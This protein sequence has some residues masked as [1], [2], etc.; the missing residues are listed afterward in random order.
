M[1]ERT[2][3]ITA[4]L[5]EC[6]AAGKVPGVAVAAVLPDG[7]VVSAASGVRDVSS[8]AAMQPDT[9]VWIASMTKAITG[10][11]AMQMVERGKLALDQ[12]ISGVLPQLAG[13]KVLEGFSADGAPRLRPARGAITLRHL[14]TH[15][16]GFVYDMWNADMAR[17][18]RTTGKPGITSCANA[19]L[20]LPLVFDPGAAWDYGIG[21]AGKAVEAV[22]GT[23]LGRYL[24]EN[25]LGPLGMRDTGFRI[26][27]D[28][29][30]RLARVHARLADGTVATEFEIPQAPE[31]EMG[32]GGLYST[33]GDYL[34]FA[35]M[36]L[37]RGTLDG[38]RVL[39]E[40][41]VA[42][43]STNAMGDLRCRPMKSVAP[44][45]TNDVDF[46]DGMQW[47]LSFLINPEA[48]PTGR[49][50]GSLAWAG[51]ANSY[52]WIDPKKNVAGVFATQL[53]PFFDPEA[54][55]LLGAFESAVYA[56]A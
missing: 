51:L 34:R 35:R 9:V 46:V 23:T 20:D 44:A 1:T 39:T 38:V 21:W 15:S 50:A 7:E 24:S 32:G 18:L 22:S 8:G 31:F 27:D 49:S 43:M 6:T 54:V 4:L 48:L 36:I 14:L 40:P 26:R 25:L 33:V 47:G 2:D 30:A 13:V 10:A 55:A 11:A 45:S 29:R 37:G 3:R 5:S 56:M 19:A 16:S 17:Y 12:P 41:T 52:Y 42:M 28:Q 53:L